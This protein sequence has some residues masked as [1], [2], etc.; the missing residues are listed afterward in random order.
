MVQRLRLGRIGADRD[1]YFANARQ[2]Q[3]IELAG[4]EA[5]AS[6]HDRV[7]ESQVISSNIPCVVLDAFDDGRIGDHWVCGPVSGRR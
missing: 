1:G 5:I 4:Q 3:H 2:M 7:G 6:G